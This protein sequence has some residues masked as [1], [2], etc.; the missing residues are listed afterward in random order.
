[1]SLH[2]S[3]CHS[4]IC[5]FCLLFIVFNFLIVNL[6]PL[7]LHSVDILELVGLSVG[8]DLGSGLPPLL[9]S[10]TIV[11]GPGG[12]LDAFLL[13]D[14]LNS[15]TSNIEWQL[16]RR[17]FPSQFGLYAI[18]NS[19]DYQGPIVIIRDGSDNIVFEVSLWRSMNTSYDVLSVTL[20]GLDPIA[21]SIPASV[22]LNDRSFR[23]LGLRLF[24]YQ[25]VV[26]IDCQVVNFVNLEQPPRPLPVNNTRV[27]VFDEGAVV[28]GHLMTLCGLK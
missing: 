25:L 23:N 24:H 26:I 19:T 9:D 5:L 2:T 1:M 3:Q 22:N 17:D 28:R 18:F 16:I 15:T 6:L 11:R 20:P 4:E 8:P 12:R 27:E 14:D 21:V 13:N 7:Y 10:A